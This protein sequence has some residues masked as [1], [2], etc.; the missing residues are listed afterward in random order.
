[1]PEE[2]SGILKIQKPHFLPGW[3]LITFLSASRAISTFFNFSLLVFTTPLL[4]IDIN[5]CKYCNIKRYYFHTNGNCI[6]IIH[7]VRQN[8]ST[9]KLVFPLFSPQYSSSSVIFSL[10]LFPGAQKHKIPCCCYHTI[11]FFD[12]TVLFFSGRK[13]RRSTVSHLLNAIQLQ[14]KDM[15]KDHHLMVQWEGYTQ[16]NPLW[17][18]TPSGIRSETLHPVEFALRR[19]TQWNSLWDVTPSGI[20]SETLHPV[21]S[22]LRRYT[23]WN[24]LW[25]VT[26]S[27]ICSETLHPVEFAPRCYTQWNSLWDI[28]PSRIRSETL[29]P[30]ESALRRYTQWNLLWDVTPSG[31]RSETLHPVESALRRYTQWNSLWGVTPSGIRSERS[32]L[33]KKLNLVMNILILELSK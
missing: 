6:K 14:F 10:T 7:D 5:E 1:M 12:L 31:I 3:F 11:C 15:C 28:T 23:Q 19:Y 2:A 27:G 29:H 17:D 32:R 18:V 8:P 16:W 26:P 9:S 4:F 22:A 20:R 30:V 13:L 25:D 24:S 33:S 21:E